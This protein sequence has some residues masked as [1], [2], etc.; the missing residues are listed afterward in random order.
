GGLRPQSRVPSFP[1]AD[2]RPCR[3]KYSPKPLSARPPC[4]GVAP[5]G[6]TLVT[7]NPSS[8]NTTPDPAPSPRGPTTRRLATRGRSVAATVVTTREYASMAASSSFR[9]PVPPSGGVPG[10]ADCG[11]AGADRGACGAVSWGSLMPVERLP[12][13][14]DAR[15]DYS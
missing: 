3:T 7:R 15:P 6:D 1:V 8:V 10:D 2:A 12:S 4:R 14:S 5:A 13:R 11:C 9:G